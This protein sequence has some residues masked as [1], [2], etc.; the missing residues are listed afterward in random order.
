MLERRMKL[1]I[2]E[3]ALD[4]IKRDL[5]FDFG[6]A[7]SDDRP[8]CITL[9]I[10]DQSEVVPMFKWKI[11]HKTNGHVMI[12]KYAYKSFNETIREDWQPGYYFTYRNYEAIEPVNG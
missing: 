6:F 10:E 11:K 12:T 7:K 4:N 3:R 5:H 1:W 9:N 2:R 8:I